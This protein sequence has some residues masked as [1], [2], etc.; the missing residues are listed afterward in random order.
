MDLSKLGLTEEAAPQV[1]WDA[2]EQGKVPPA[3]YPA[4]YLLRLVMPEDRDTWFEKVEVEVIKGKPESKRPFLKINYGANVVA[5]SQGV[6]MANE[7]GTPI[8]LPPQNVSTFMNPRML[9]HRGAELLR[10]MGVRVEGSF[11]EQIE[12]VLAQLNAQ[13]ATFHAEV[14]WRCYFKSTGTTVST[15]PRSKKSGELPW[16][17]NAQNEW[18]MLAVNPMTGEKGYGYPTIEAFKV[19]TAEAANIATAGS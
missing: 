12:D 1:D 8:S 2:P 6:P 15:H 19:P 5:N 14:I 13:G 16:P 3:V 10:A 18:E 9:I 11:L 4:E 7:D 17:R